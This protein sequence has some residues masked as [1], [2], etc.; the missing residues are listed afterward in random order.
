[1]C[2]LCDVSRIHVAHPKHGHCHPVAFA[3]DPSVLAVNVAAVERTPDSV[4]RQRLGMILEVVKVGTQIIPRTANGLPRA[5][6]QPTQL[7]A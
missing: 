7:V 1:M 6:H 4:P 5:Q 2:L 3:S